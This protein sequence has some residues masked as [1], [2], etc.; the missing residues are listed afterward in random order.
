MEK[1]QVQ[2][3]N[4]QSFFYSPAAIVSIF[5]ASIAIKEEKKVIQMRGIYKKSGT[6]NY[7]GFF[8]DRLKDEAS[9]YQITLIIP[10][11]LHNQLDDNRTIEFNAFINR[12]INKSGQIEIQIN[13]IDLISQQANKYSD[14][15]IKKLNVI[16]KK[17]E[18]GLKDLDTLIKNAIFHNQPVR[19]RVILGK[20]AI[21]D[22][23]IKK[24]MGDTIAL[25][26]IT[27]HP[28]TLTSPQAIINMLQSLDNEEADVICIAR[29]GGENLDIFDNINI[30]EAALQSKAI[31]A[32]AIGQDVN[33]TLFEKIADK[34]FSL[35]F[36]FG[37]YLKEIYN[38]TIE[39]FE[40][41][42]AKVIKDVETRL[43]TEYGK[44]L[45]TLN[46]QLLSTKEINEKTLTET[47]KNYNEK[48]LLL[49]SKMKSFEELSF[50]TSHEKAQL[51]QQ[52]ITNFKKQIDII[53]KD[54]N[55]KE[56]LLQ[57][58]NQIA[59]NYKKQAEEAKQKSGVDIILIIFLICI[60]IIIGL[61][62]GHNK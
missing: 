11:L 32:S 41:S 60:G 18:L 26:Q 39:D 12:R 20:A 49:Q 6:I 14:E 17:I 1:I 44:K 33:V 58:A 5:N 23:D 10:A 35:P 25:Y 31:I 48:M 57:R 47:Q 27:Y 50:K 16:N 61:F 37:S 30:C 53:T 36:H 24:G 8:Y 43:N 40:S 15:E 9:D 55:Q 3:L 19:I 29:G 56:A 28:V 38:T 21:I 46:Q 7:S 4:T 2:N 54:A 34:K 62:F 51:H 13:L 42:R 45:E 22:H 52:E 59:N